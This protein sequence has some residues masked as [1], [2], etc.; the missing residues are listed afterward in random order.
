MEKDVSRKPESA[1]EVQQNTL[2][3]IRTGR[4]LTG[5]R[6]SARTRA[7][8]G[9]DIITEPKWQ[10]LPSLVSSGWNVQE[11]K[12]D[13]T[14]L[15]VLEASL[16]SRWDVWRSGRGGGYFWWSVSLSKSGRQAKYADGGEGRGRWRFSLS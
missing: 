4:T 2:L 9:H 1:G 6:A 14:S 8:L 15:E 13:P 10:R 11:V 16:S 5:R 12:N 3:G 7:L